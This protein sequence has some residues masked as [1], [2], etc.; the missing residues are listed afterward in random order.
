MFT[1]IRLRKVPLLHMHMSV[2]KGALC[3]TKSCPYEYVSSC[4]VMCE[5]CD[6]WW[7]LIK[8]S[9][10][11]VIIHIIREHVHRFLCQVIVNKARP[12][13]F[14]GSQC[15]S[16]HNCRYTLEYWR[17]SNTLLLPHRGYRTIL[18]L[19]LRSA[20]NCDHLPTIHSFKQCSVSTGKTLWR[21]TPITMAISK[22][23]RIG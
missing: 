14:L 20:S 7:G 2:T 22:D 23:G 16:S 6:A 12:K 19:K 21:P 5:A 3:S 11:D 13:L 15:N 17:Y 1:G 9:N 8:M 4:Y 10:I 18:C